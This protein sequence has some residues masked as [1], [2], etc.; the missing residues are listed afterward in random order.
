[1]CSKRSKKIARN[2]SHKNQSPGLQNS[3]QIGPP[4]DL[5]YAFCA[6]Q[7]TTLPNSTLNAPKSTLNAPKST[8]NAPSL[9]TKSVA[10]APTIHEEP[11]SG[12]RANQALKKAHVLALSTAHVLRL[13]KA[14]VL[15]LNKAHVASQHLENYALLRFAPSSFHSL[16]TPLIN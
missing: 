13:N 1:M 6:T 5:K 11:H 2:K 3:T 14:D 15:A 12:G 10:W 4:N 16:R 9:S 8:L 7:S